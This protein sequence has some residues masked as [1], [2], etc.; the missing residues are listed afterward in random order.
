MNTCN[1]LVQCEIQY[2]RAIFWIYLVLLIVL[3]LKMMPYNANFKSVQS[4]P[5]KS[6]VTALCYLNTMSARIHLTA[7]VHNALQNSDYLKQVSVGTG[8]LQAETSQ[9]QPQ[10]G[11][12]SSCMDLMHISDHGVT[13]WF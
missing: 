2:L 7:A 9:L 12:L 13:E 11:A 6:Y 4:G 3:Y 8:V 1:I 10:E 5:V